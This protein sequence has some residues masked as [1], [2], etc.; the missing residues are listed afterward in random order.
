MN[1]EYEYYTENGLRSD[2]LGFYLLSSNGTWKRMQW[3]IV[4]ETVIS[5]LYDPNE[6]TEETVQCRI[7]L[8]SGKQRGLCTQ[9]IYVGCKRK[10]SN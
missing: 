8:E 7:D 3:D 2:S 10:D 1:P 9:N 5:A 4:N 6:M